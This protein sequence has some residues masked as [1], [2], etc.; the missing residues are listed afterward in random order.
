M[1][2]LKVDC[3]KILG[4]HIGESEKNVKKVF[5]DYPAISKLLHK[6]PVLLL[7]EADQLLGK[8]IAASNSAD[9]SN[10]NVQNL[11]LEA[12]ERFDGILVATTN[13]KEL[14]DS[15]YSRRFTY[16]LEL[17]EPDAE[18]R[19][20]LWQMHLPEKICDDSI[21]LEQLA[22]FDLTGGEIRLVMEQAVRKMAYQGET[23]LKGQML[24][25]SACNNDPP[26]A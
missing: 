13:M 24:C 22:V 14:L 23:K 20:K 8:R 10:N 18:L 17:P 5:D 25:E 9:Q 6:K 2:V 15:A 16:K 1:P 26:L 7:N 12:L 4:M 19:K 11:F 21:D 3:A